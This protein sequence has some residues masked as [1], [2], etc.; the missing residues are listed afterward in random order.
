VIFLADENFPR[1]SVELLR[2]AGYDV[3]RMLEISRSEKDPGV[4]SI[5]VEMQRILLTFDRDFGELIFHKKLK[6]PPAVLYFRFDPAY[7][8]E[9]FEILTDVLKDFEINDNYT[10]ITRRGVRQRPLA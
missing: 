4:L 2:K 1:K 5:S 3:F 7:P 10:T 6:P 9:P 8:E